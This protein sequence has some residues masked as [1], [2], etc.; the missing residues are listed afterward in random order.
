MAKK[1]SYTV[2][3]EGEVVG[4]RKSHRTYTH[5]VVM[6]AAPRPEGS[7]RNEYQRSNEAP[8][9]EGWELFE[10]RAEPGDRYGSPVDQWHRTV[11]DAGELVP[12]RVHAYCGR[13]DLADKAL[14]SNRTVSYWADYLG[15]AP[16]I[17]QVEALHPTLASFCL[18]TG[19]SP[20]MVKAQGIRSYHNAQG[21]PALHSIQEGA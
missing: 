11:S 16:V 13:R 7:T 4:T 14:K 18:A 12:A 9:G 15:V 3:L 20:E 10:S 5:A 21:G 19:F 1:I 6:P 8:T 17:V 2:R